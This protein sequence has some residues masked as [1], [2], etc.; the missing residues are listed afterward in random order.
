[1]DGYFLLGW[2]FLPNFLET[3]DDRLDGCKSFSDLR[4]YSILFFS[5]FLALVAWLYHTCKLHMFFPFSH[6]NPEIQDS[7]LRTK[8]ILMDLSVL[9]Q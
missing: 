6:L 3:R 4:T 5:S 9:T 8:L 1:M 7:A 2:K